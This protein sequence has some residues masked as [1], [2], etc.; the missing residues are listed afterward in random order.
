MVAP[1]GIDGPIEVTPPALDANIGLINPPGFV[2]WLEL[3]GQPLF[4]LE[5]VTLHPPPDRR[6][7]RLP[8][9]FG[10]QLFNIAQ[11]EPIPQ[12]PA[13]AQRISSGAVCRHLKM[14]G[15]GCVLHDLLSLPATPAKLAKHPLKLIL[16]SPPQTDY[17]AVSLG[18]L[19]PYALNHHWTLAPL[20]RRPTTG[21]CPV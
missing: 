13:T 6:V 20:F 14:A 10:E 19:W 1:A 11:R 12:L 15:R 4:Q 9:A 5:T 16:P 21:A 18:A 3:P 8:A 7:I 17:S 2:G